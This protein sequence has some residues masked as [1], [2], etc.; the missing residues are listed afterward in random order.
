MD[1]PG[2]LPRRDVRRITQATGEEELAASWRGVGEPI[3]DCCSGLFS[4]LELDR[5]TGFPLDHRCAV[6]HP[7]PD[8]YVGHPKPDEVTAPQL[9]INGEVEKR[10]V[11][12]ASLKLEANA[13]CPDLLRF[14]RAFLAGET[15][16]SGS[17]AWRGADCPYPVIA[18]EHHQFDRRPRSLHM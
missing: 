2:V 13:N 12:S 4:D 6:L 14:E 11:T 1:D 9:A 17:N 10:K 15:A 3:A 16:P 8:A 5:P 7:A 18:R